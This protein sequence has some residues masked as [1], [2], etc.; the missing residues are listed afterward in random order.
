MKYPQEIKEDMFSGKK[1]GKRIKDGATS[2]R[3][4]QFATAAL[5]LAYG[6]CSPREV[7][8]SVEH[9]PALY[10]HL[11]MGEDAIIDIERYVAD[12]D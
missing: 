1:R 7:A 2:Y 5:A 11:R 3:R 10:P 4:H 6:K 8:T 12:I 9:V